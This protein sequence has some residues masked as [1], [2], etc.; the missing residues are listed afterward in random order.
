[1]TRSIR[2][3]SVGEMPGGARNKRPYCF[4]SVIC[5]SLGRMPADD[6]CCILLLLLHQRGVRQLFGRCHSEKMELGCKGMGLWERCREMWMGWYNYTE[7]HK[8]R[9]QETMQSV[10]SWNES[11][12]SASRGRISITAASSM[13]CYG[14]GEPSI[15]S[16]MGGHSHCCYLSP[17]PVPVSAIGTMIPRVY[18]A[19]SE[20]SEHAAASI[21]RV[22]ERTYLLVSSYRSVTR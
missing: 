15:V 4:N 7:M 22:E 13:G 8:N 1:M 19:R 21:D 11:N 14:R 5:I 18:R 17:N 9:M 6:G 20:M 16:V 3:I 2:A 12:I 10:Y